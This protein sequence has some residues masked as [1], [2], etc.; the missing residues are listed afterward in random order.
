[1]EY[2]VV[3]GKNIEEARYNYNNKVEDKILGFAFNLTEVG[4][5]IEKCEED[6]W[7]LRV[8]DDPLMEALGLLQ[9]AIDRLGDVLLKNRDKVESLKLEDNSSRK[10]SNENRNYTLYK[11][12]DTKKGISF[13]SYEEARDYGKTL[14]THYFIVNNE[15]RVIFES[16]E[17]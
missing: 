6:T 7:V 15:K 3:I 9:K 5:L 13:Q 4:R 10:I 16:P 8:E 1:M 14:N 11:D 17:E 12:T 2:V